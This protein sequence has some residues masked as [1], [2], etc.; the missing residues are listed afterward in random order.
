VSL[1]ALDG[2]SADSKVV[3]KFVEAVDDSLSTSSFNQ[4]E[5]SLGGL[6][7]PVVVD[8][9]HILKRF[10]SRLLNCVVQNGFSA[11]APIANVS[12]CRQELGLASAVL[13]SWHE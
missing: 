9:L 6:D 5:S 10:R 12:W 11:V 13:A 3:P 2:D 4:D 1:P 7:F 8:P